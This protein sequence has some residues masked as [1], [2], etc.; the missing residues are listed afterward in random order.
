MYKS[1]K[2]ESRNGEMRRKNIFLDNKGGHEASVVEV[3]I[4]QILHK[5]VDIGHT[6]TSY[7]VLVMESRA[8]MNPSRSISTCGHPH[9]PIGSAPT[10]PNR[11]PSN[12]H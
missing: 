1:T 2:E 10:S 6:R 9:P 4:V 12:L 11:A 5:P 8:S 3:L 7:S